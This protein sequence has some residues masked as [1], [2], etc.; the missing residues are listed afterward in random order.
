MNNDT[1][2]GLC[3]DAIRHL[4]QA[5]ELRQINN[6][7]AIG[8]NEQ[9]KGVRLY[10]KALVCIDKA[11]NRTYGWYFSAFRFGYGIEKSKKKAVPGRGRLSLCVLFIE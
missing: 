5:K 7:S 3:W 9:A 10:K 2:S 8:S 1:L 6:Q 11:N 4:D